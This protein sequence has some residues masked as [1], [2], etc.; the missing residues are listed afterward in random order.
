VD[1][2][3]GGFLSGVV[4]IMLIGYIL[5]DIAKQDYCSKYDSRY[6]YNGCL[7]HSKQVWEFKETK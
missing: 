7:E 1:Y 3:M 6:V 4:F 5:A 2:F